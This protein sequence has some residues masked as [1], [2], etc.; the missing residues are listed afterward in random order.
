MPSQ[1]LHTLFGEDVIAGLC[2]RQGSGF[3]PISAAYRGIFALG[4]QGPDIFYHNRRTRP[5]ALEYG[6]LLHRRNYGVFCANLFEGN[7]PLTMNALATYALG[8]LTHAVLDRWCHP[9]IVYKSSGSNHPFFERIIDVLML[10]ELRHQEVSSWE[11][12]LLVQA[13]EN[14]PE[15]LPERITQALAAAFPEKTNRDHQLARR[16]DNAFL[17]S[18]RYYRLSD[19]AQ[20]HMSAGD[21]ENCPPLSLRH[22]SL[23]FPENLPADIDFLNMRKEPWY[24]PYRPPEPQPDTRSF[25]EIYAGAVTAAVNSLL[26]CVADAR[27]IGNGGLSIHDAEGKPCA[28]NLADPLPLDA[29][30]RNQADLRTGTMP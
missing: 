7:P 20:T 17:D 13:C 19:P 9:Y 14:P 29:V 23:L 4:C 28:P 10:R 22:L 3:E 6:A 11:Q 27:N 18:A 25:P 12:G 8:F 2:S 1:I 15:G 30:L 21:T 5:G 16:I 24:Y 26:D